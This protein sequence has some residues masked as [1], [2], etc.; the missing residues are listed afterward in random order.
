MESSETDQHSLLKVSKI[1]KTV[2]HAFHCFNGVVNA[3]NNAGRE[4][5]DEVV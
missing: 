4:A 1:T 5:M 3:F 2:T